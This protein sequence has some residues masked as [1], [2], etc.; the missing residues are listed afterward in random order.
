MHHAIQVSKQAIVIHQLYCLL[1]YPA[2]PEP[3]K[4]DQ[5]SSS[6]KESSDFFC[7]RNITSIIYYRSISANNMKKVSKP[8]NVV[9][10]PK[11]DYHTQLKNAYKRRYMHYID[12]PPST[13]LN[14]L[15]LSALPLEKNMRRKYYLYF[16]DILHELLL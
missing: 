7:C 10:T 15:Q 9:K 13:F 12:L 5:L 6:E 8:S 16:L 14:V 3:R 1:L 11:K 2:S 4:K